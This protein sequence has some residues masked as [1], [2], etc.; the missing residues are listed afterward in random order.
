M[1][2][3][4]CITH[5]AKKQTLSLSLSFFLYLSFPL[6]FLFNPVRSLVLLI[7]DEKRRAALFLPPSRHAIRYYARYWVSLFYR[8]FLLLLLLFFFFFFFFFCFYFVVA[9]GIV[10]IVICFLARYS[11]TRSQCA[12]ARVHAAMKFV[13]SSAIYLCFLSDRE[14]EARVTNALYRYNRLIVEEDLTEITR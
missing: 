10:G 14:R 4:S 6:S 8:D 13:A 12:R 2:T 11:S 5:L 7:L 9:F 3:W 1:G